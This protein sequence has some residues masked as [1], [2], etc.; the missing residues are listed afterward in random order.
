MKL[1]QQQIDMLQ[2]EMKKIK[3]ESSKQLKVM[4][5]KG[6]EK[7]K[8]YKKREKTYQKQLNDIQTKIKH[9]TKNGKE[10]TKLQNKI[11]KLKK[12]H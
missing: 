8:E 5:L 9:K 7:S 2:R 3:H 1:Q 4:K 10:V 12:N 6:L 11:E